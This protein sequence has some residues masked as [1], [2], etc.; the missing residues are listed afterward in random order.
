MAPV[1]MEYYDLLGVK[2]DVGDAELKKAYRKMAI[3][4]H[5]DKNPSPD[6]EEMF[7]EISKAYQILSDPNLRASY[8]KNGKK[9]AD[10]INPTDDTQGFFASVFGGDAF[11]DLIG[12]ISLLSNMSAKAEVLMTD[13]ERE[14]FEAERNAASG[15]PKPPEPSPPT[16]ETRPSNLLD[17]AS[18]AAGAARMSLAPELVPK[19]GTPS[20]D[21]SRS[22]EKPST[23]GRVKDKKERAK[24]R[25]EQREKLTKLEEENQKALEERVTILSQKLLDRLRPFLELQNPDDVNDPGRRA[26]EEK[27]RKEADDL[28]YESFGVEVIP[29]TGNVYLM[30][31]TSYFKSKKFLGIPGFFSKLKDV[32]STVKDFWGLASGAHS[33]MKVS[34]SP[35]DMTKIQNGQL[36]EE[37]LRAL[38][39]DLTGKILLISWQGTRFEVSQ[40]LR[41]VIDR[42]LKHNNGVSEEELLRR[43]KG[44][45]LLGAIYKSIEP[46]EPAE[47]RREL[48]RYAFYHWMDLI[49]VN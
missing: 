49:R 18:T 48:E 23:E 44:I 8:D 11:E 1:D 31:A 20:S 5:P 47:E 35:G 17:P 32:G 16:N 10:Q 46:D 34:Q 26:F 27:I 9:M 42:T 30:K 3:R 40:V 4:Y 41:Q 39:A 12:K 36:P 25:A 2:A 33:V 45:F 38:E 6:A 19:P 7:K 22:P 13:E 15:S 28:K 29:C 43:A 24:A 37:D 21:A 14:A